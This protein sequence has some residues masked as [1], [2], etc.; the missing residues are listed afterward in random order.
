[1]VTHLELSLPKVLLIQTK[2]ARP[3][4]AKKLS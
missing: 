3:L 2:K 1:M 4:T